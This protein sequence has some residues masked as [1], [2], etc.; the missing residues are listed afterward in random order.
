MKNKKACDGLIVDLAEE[1]LSEL[2]VIATETIKAQKQR[3]KT[4]ACPRIVRQPQKCTRHV[5]GTQK[6]K[7]QRIF[8]AIRT[9]S[10]PKLMSDTKSQIQGAQRTR[11]IN[12]KQTNK[13]P[14]A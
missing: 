11:R 6:R 3:K 9:E 1:R 8:E 5:R 4:T 7:E 12:V 10:F 13:N 2:E 14:H